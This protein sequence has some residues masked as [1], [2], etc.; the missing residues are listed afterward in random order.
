VGVGVGATMGEMKTGAMEHERGVPK[1]AD[2]VVPVMMA[3][4]P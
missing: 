4:L 2:G 3:T 1:G